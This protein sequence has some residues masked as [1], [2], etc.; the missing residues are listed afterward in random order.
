[1]SKSKRRRKA[2]IKRYGVPK[3]SKFAFHNM[4]IWVKQLFLLLAFFVVG[5]GRFHYTNYQLKKDGIEHEAYI[6]DKRPIGRHGTAY[7]YY[8]FVDRIEYQGYTTYISEGKILH[9]GDTIRIM[10]SKKDPSFNH[11]MKRL[12]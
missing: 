10:Y 8:F 1:M 2:K 12:D 3:K 11:S 4:N 9:I 5:R 7:L 6:Y